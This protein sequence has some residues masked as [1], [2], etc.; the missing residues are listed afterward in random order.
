MS[1]ELR[2]P[3]NAI[4]GYVELLNMQIGG[5]VTD[6]QRGY[7]SR[8][9][10]SQQH[11]LTLLEDVLGF[12][13]LE[14]GRLAVSLQPVIIYDAIVALEGMMELEIRLVADPQIML[15]HGFFQRNRRQVIRAGS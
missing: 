8:I 12:A 15:A 4:S 6:Q 13:R 7:L 10:S 1:H 9:Q 11:L 5:P 3:L 2:T 14:T